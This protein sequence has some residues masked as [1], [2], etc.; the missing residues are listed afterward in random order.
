MTRQAGT[1]VSERTITTLVTALGIDQQRLLSLIET[2]SEIYST[3]CAMHCNHH[4][5][6]HH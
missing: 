5:R 2:R 6:G 4:C 3:R 1:V